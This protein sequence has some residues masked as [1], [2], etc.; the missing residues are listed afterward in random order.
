MNEFRSAV[1]YR[2][3]GKVICLYLAQDGTSKKQKR[4]PIENRTE[5][6]ND[7]LYEIHERIYKI[8][9]PYSIANLLLKA[10][11]FAWISHKTLFC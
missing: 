4:M 11:F 3:L 7:I 5:S 2:M 10:Y 9:L 6:F 8:K 1:K